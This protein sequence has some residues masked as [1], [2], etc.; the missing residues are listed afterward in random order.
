MTSS[1][2]SCL[3]LALFAAAYVIALSL[4]V[5]LGLGLSNKSSPPRATPSI[6][7]VTASATASSTG[8]STSTA[9]ATASAIAPVPSPRSGSR[10]PSEAALAL[11]RQPRPTIPAGTVIDKIYEKGFGFKTAVA[12][13]DTAACCSWNSC[14]ACGTEVSDGSSNDNT[15][16]WGSEGVCRCGGSYQT[17]LARPLLPPRLQASAKATAAARGAP[18]AQCPL[19]TSRR[20]R[21]SP[22]AAGTRAA[23]VPRR[24]HTASERRAPTHAARAVA[25]GART[26]PWRPTATWQ[27]CV[28]PT[29]S[30]PTRWRT[31]A[32]TGASARRRCLQRP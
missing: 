9:S 5:G 18:Q 13:A 8:T 29:R 3:T 32:S 30:A 12:P 1:S 2:P 10:L 14:G 15:W 22:A 19:Q 27:A 7:P 6:A 16:C 31:R 20:I 4:G 26:A 25:R 17:T 24:R 28:T 23:S 21:H 11:A